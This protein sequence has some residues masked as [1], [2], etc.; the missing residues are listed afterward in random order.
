MYIELDQALVAGKVED[1]NKPIDLPGRKKVGG[2]LWGESKYLLNKYEV[3]KQDVRQVLASKNKEETKPEEV[4]FG[5][6]GEVFFDHDFGFFGAILACYN[7]HWVLRT[8]PD[9]WWN[10]IVRL[11]FIFIFI[12]I[13][14]SIFIIIFIFILFFMFM[15]IIISIYIYGRP[16]QERRPGRG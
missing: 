1:I 5:S 9:D 8:S 7:N 13:Y 16:C 3:K 11:N 10:V 4:I 14:I 6:E 15:F 12:F 2:P